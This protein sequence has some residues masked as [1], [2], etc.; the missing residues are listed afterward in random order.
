MVDKIELL[1]YPPCI[2]TFPPTTTLFVILVF[3]NDAGQQIV[4]WTAI[5]LD[6]KAEPMPV[7]SST[8]Q[9]DVCI[10]YCSTVK[11][12]PNLPSSSISPSQ[13][14]GMIIRSCLPQRITR[15]SPCVRH[16]H[17]SSSRQDDAGLQNHYATLDLPTDAAPGE[18]KKSVPAHPID[19]H[20]SPD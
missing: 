5:L 10:P 14:Q 15:L 20:R 1:V 18:I 9:V 17:L 2:L 3:D 12:F 16:F 11:C 13:C 7:T 19:Q 6:G 4:P 8:P